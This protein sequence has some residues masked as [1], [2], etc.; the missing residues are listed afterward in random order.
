ME[1]AIR[2]LTAS[3][4]QGNQFAQYTLGKL[5]FFDGDV[6][7]DKEKSLYW[8]IASAAQGNI[9]AQFLIDHINEYRSPSVLLAATSLMHRLENLF[10]EDYRKVNGSSAFH[11]DRKRRRKLQEKKQAGGHARDDHEQQQ[12]Q[13]TL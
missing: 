5:Y 3:A 13:F 10:R 8:L 2:W 6:P 1:A 11:I 7:R 9:Y 12:H 4:E